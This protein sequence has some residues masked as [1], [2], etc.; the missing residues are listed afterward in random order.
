[1]CQKTLIGW[2]EL[3]YTGFGN[4]IGYSFDL[5]DAKWEQ[6]TTKIKSKNVSFQP[7]IQIIGIVIGQEFPHGCVFMKGTSKIDKNNTMCKKVLVEVNKQ[8]HQQTK[9]P[10]SA[11]ARSYH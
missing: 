10:D 9:S 1:M 7:V 11:P 4:N 5:L 8:N 2:D 3:V 6:I